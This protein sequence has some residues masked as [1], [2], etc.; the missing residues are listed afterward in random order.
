MT[1]RCQIQSLLISLLVWIKRPSTIAV[2]ISAIALGT[3][4]YAGGLILV[5]KYLPILIETEL[6][7]TLNRRVFIGQVQS[8]SLTGFRLDPSSIPA[9]HTESNYVSL[10]AIEASFNPLPLLQG[11]ALVADVTLIEPD[12]F[13]QQDKSGE[14]IDTDDIK[15][16][17]LPVPIDTN[18]RI[19]NGEITLIPID[20]KNKLIFG[21][22]ATITIPYGQ[23]QSV[24]YD[25]AAA[26]ASGE[27]R[28]KGETLSRTGKSQ[29]S[30]RVENL[31]LVQLTSFIPHSP[32]SLTSG[33]LDANLE[34]SL[35]S[36][37]EIPS[38]Q[39]TVIFE[40]IKAQ[41]QLPLPL[42]ASAL[43][44]FQGQ[45]MSVENT[46]G[47]YGAV[48]AIV[49]GEVDW[50]KGFDLAINV[51]PFSLANFLKTLPVQ[52]PVAVNGEM[53]ALLQVTG[54]LTAPIV[55]GRLSSTKTTYIDKVG[56]AQIHSSFLG[57]SRKLQLQDFQA[58]PVAG[59]EIRGSGQ[60]KLSTSDTQM[61]L[62]FDFSAQIPDANAFASVY[63]FPA[64]ITLG[65]STAKAQILGTIANP[66]ALVKWQLQ[67]RLATATNKIDISGT[68]Q[69]SLIKQNRLLSHTK[70]EIG[71]GTMIVNAN[72][73]LKNRNWQASLNATAIPLK[74]FFPVLVQQ[75][76]TLQNGNVK[77]TGRFDTL[78]PATWKAVADINLNVAGG[79]VALSSKL[80]S[81]AVLV[82][83]TVSQIQLATFGT[84][85]AQVSGDVNL[86]GEIEN[87]NPQAILAKAN[88]QVDV[89]QGKVDLTSEL[90]RGQWQANIKAVNLNT[91]LLSQQ[92]LGQS[93]ASLTLPALNAQLSLSGKIDSLLN[94]DT[95]AT[96][97]ANTVSVQMEEQ[98]LNASGFL[99]LT[100]LT[101]NPE[102]SLDLDIA[103]RSN[104]QTLP[105]YLL[106]NQAFFP[107]INGQAN[108][109]GRL[110]GK[111]LLSAPLAPGNLNLTGNLRLLDFAINNVAFEPIVAGEVIATG[112]EVAINLN[113]ERSGIAARLD[114][115]TQAKCLVP[116][117]PISLEVRGGTAEDSV[118]LV[119]ERDGDRFNIQAENFSLALLNLTPATQFGIKEPVVGQLTGKLDI[120]LFTLATA[121]NV[122]ITQPSL[123]NIKANKFAGNFSYQNGLIQLTTATLEF[124]QSLYL[125]DGSLNLDSSEVS[126]K[127]KVAAGE[128]Q[129]ILTTFGW[130][131]LPDLLRG[132]KHPSYASA[133]DVQP[134]PVGPEETLFNQLRL[135][136]HIDAW[137]QQQIAKAQG[138][139]AQLDIRGAYTGDIDI[140]G[141]LANPQL[142]F[143]FW[144]QDWQW[145][146]RLPIISISPTGPVVKKSPVIQVK[147]AIARGSFA[148][149]AIALEPLQIE[150]DDAVMSVVG[151]LSAANKPGMLLD[152]A[153]LSLDTVRNILALPIDITGKLNAKALLE[154]SP[155]NPQV[156]DGEIYFVDGTINNQPLEEIQGKFSYIDS[157][158][159]FN[160]TQPSLLQ[161]QITAPFPPKPGVDEQLS[162]NVKLDTEAFAQLDS[163]T[164]GQFEWVDGQGEL[165]LQARAR[166]GTEA[167]AVRDIV[168]D[169]VSKANASIKFNDAT[170]KTAVLDEDLK[171]NGEI[172]LHNQRLRVENL[173]G[174]LAQ[175]QQLSIT[176]VLPLFKPIGTD[177]SDASN[178]LTVSLE[179]GTLDLENLY[180]GQINAEVVVTGTALS[181]VFGGEARLARGYASVSNDSMEPL[182]SLFDNDF[183][184][185]FDNFRVVLGDRFLVNLSAFRRLAGAS[186][187]L[188]G[189]VELNG[190]LKSLRPEGTIQL[191]RGNVNVLN[192]KFFLSRDYQSK[193][194]FIPA[195]GLL[196]PNLDI[197]METVVSTESPYKR[198]QP[199][200][201]EIRDDIVTFS[202]PEQV[203]I[204]LGIKGQTSQLIAI[205]ELVA[206]NCQ[207]QQN[208]NLPIKGSDST[209]APERLQKL[210]ACIGAP[211][212]ATRSTSQ[213]LNAPIVTLF[214]TPRRSKSGI[215]AL[216]S[217]QVLADLSQIEIINNRR[218]LV[219]FAL[220]RYVVAP[221]FRSA[222]V[223]IQNLASQA[224]QSIGLT[225][226][227][228]FPVLE[229]IRSLDADGESFVGMSYDYGFSEIKVQYQVEF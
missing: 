198:L 173:T 164:Q 92:L 199:I 178:P 89:A 109:Q 134:K 45:R 24:K 67:P 181:P 177:D 161:V 224:G 216:L 68:S 183:Q 149:G 36:F 124:G 155:T 1:R 19:A 75:P 78:N 18:I 119:G 8:F 59:G 30:A 156:Q 95:A 185:N 133:A 50:T 144:G 113:G 55:N 139:P 20:K 93:Q 122:Q 226:L 14:L 210:A 96:I 162:L 202:R 127:I 34:I 203:D 23:R 130:W 176:G 103:A 62:A 193:V 191:R 196:N 126:G 110:Q 37:K 83:A 52:S 2:S 77:L 85:A 79:N 48:K 116:Y 121:G 189:A 219:E 172:A 87:L 15:E 169:L 159:R 44:R 136:S 63:S 188:A 131:T 186:F 229:G 120:N 21:L 69:I 107:K 115:C 171:L 27:L 187:R 9:T 163:F 167:I 56:F 6:S 168:R 129:D 100:N 209:M 228:I 157:R 123:G 70:L 25:I 206:D 7:K 175:N 142:N 153:N 221:A 98:S 194:E 76:A 43:L 72:G 182:L 5:K 192:S 26:I 179:K 197:E 64:N 66:Q 10:P 147:Q 138:L 108:F 205:D 81:G 148:K 38:V 143:Q 152:V 60:V 73:N 86:L 40:Q 195:Q 58:I 220:T 101:T 99:T 158:L 217:D 49:S 57:N 145:L 137:I 17:Q 154:G 33:E 166:I 214:S 218:N 94:A 71:G 42:Q 102:S 204:T 207:A 28:V 91:S 84:V 11:R 227:R 160:T 51:D 151:N 41:T 16:P 150:L 39:G 54:P 125:L 200:K 141:T 104:L 3:V 140:A 165:Q 61:P 53:R 82:A 223:S 106:V 32:A 117:L 112:Q 65:S 35:P 208:I 47:S 174:E 74:P 80:N 132:I 135:L 12:V 146:P 97:A 190:S 128:V 46:K 31:P 4:S 111:N 212:L 29:V 13:I 225:E 215:L 88:L 105:R 118:L 170:I 180:Q 90:E 201:G 114:S 22:N 211:A 213:L 184:P 222:L